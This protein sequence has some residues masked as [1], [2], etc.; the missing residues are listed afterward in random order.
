MES[1]DIDRPE[2]VSE[3]ILTALEESSDDQLRTIIH[4]AQ[5]LLREHPRV[6]DTI[7]PRG[8]EE[9]VQVIDHDEY[10]I[11]VVDRPD[12][13]GESHGPIAYR[14][15]WAP[16]TDGGE[17]R[18]QWHYLGQVHDSKGARND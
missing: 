11:V 12:E 9:I 17:G 4:Y 7:E 13:S 1:S 6:T 10:T 16:S 8:G 18:Y 15:T 5:R 3:E 2:H 14:V